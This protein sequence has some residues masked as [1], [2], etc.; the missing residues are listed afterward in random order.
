MNTKF[1]QM[2]Q[3]RHYILSMSFVYSAPYRSL[4]KQGVPTS[5]SDA[6][7]K[8]EILNTLVFVFVAVPQSQATKHFQSNHFY[9]LTKK[10]HCKNSRISCIELQ[11]AFRRK[12]HFLHFTAFESTG[13]LLPKMQ[14]SKIMGP[15]INLKIFWM[16]SYICQQFRLNSRKCGRVQNEV[17]PL[18]AT[19][20]SPHA[21]DVSRIVCSSTIYKVNNI[22]KVII[23]E[24]SH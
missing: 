11:T 5:L 16:W 13:H 21:C 9:T 12:G 24:T 22:S 3:S 19:S 14:H 10:A 6:K 8:Q 17:L 15:L 18:Q 4:G 7:C 2:N 1:T 23:H 20:C